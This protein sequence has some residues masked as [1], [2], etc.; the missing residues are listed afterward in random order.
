MKDFYSNG[1]LLISGEYVV[2]DG[3]TALSVPTTYGQS[4]K[5]EVIDEPLVRWQSL[6]HKGAL[7]FEATFRPGKWNF[8][9]SGDQRKSKIAERLQMI[10]AEADK[11]NP[12]LFSAHAGYAVTTKLDFPQ[13]WGLGSSSTLINNLAKWFRIDSYQL[14]AKTF[15]GSGYDIASA[16][17]GR[18]VTYALT[19]GGR[20]IL[21]TGFEPA[22]KDD[23]FFVYLNRKQSSRDSIAHYKAQPKHKL[24]EAVEKVSGLTQQIVTSKTISEFE[25]YLE[26]HETIISQLINTPKIKT[27]LFPD[28]PGVVKSLGGWGGDFILATGKEENKQYFQDIGY[29]TIVP[30][31]QMVL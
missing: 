1:K 3:A 30:Y 9:S 31:S 10:L 27:S 21:T 22:F 19:P 11:L 24:Q 25:L 15:G 12:E 16:Q 18:P 14:L 8:Q 7:W 13:N 2:L 17:N 26:I 20:T 4:M 23:L 6:D 5:V 28:Y 29:E